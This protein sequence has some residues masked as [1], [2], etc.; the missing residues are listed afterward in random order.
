MLLTLL[1]LATASPAPPE[2]AAGP[3]IVVA[4]RQ[5]EALSSFVAA[6]TQPGK[7]GQ[8]ARWTGICPVVLGIP[9][10]QQ[11]F[12]LARIRQVAAPLRL[13][14]QA[15]NCRPTTIIVISPDASQLATEFAEAYPST[16]KADGQWR[17]RQFARSTA[18]VRWLAISDPCGGGCLLGS[19]LALP[20]APTLQ[21]MIVIVDGARIAGYTLGEVSDYVAMVALGNPPPDARQPESIL[22]MFDRTRMQDTRFTLTATDRSLLYGL[23]RSSSATSA[24][25]QRATISTRIQ[26]DRAAGDRR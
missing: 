12:M 25:N 3:D 18:P 11:R 26:R 5:R 8:L 6:M 19:R 22:S 2:P 10:D 24:A 4:A 13:R 7:S 1:A 21:L 9:P 14:R 16:L 23:Y 15:V 20:T 17:L